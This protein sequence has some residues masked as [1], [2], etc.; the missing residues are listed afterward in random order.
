MQQLEQGLR[1]PR[2]AQPDHDGHQ[3]Q[4]VELRAGVHLLG[5]CAAR[6]ASG[7]HA[8]AMCA[9]AWMGRYWQDSCQPHALRVQPRCPARA[10]NVLHGAPSFAC[11]AQS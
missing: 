9:E 5:L 6:P 1:Q 8:P 3:V 2:W 10:R 11:T 7:E 4:D